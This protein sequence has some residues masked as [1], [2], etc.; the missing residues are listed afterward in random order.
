MQERQAM[1]AME[2]DLAVPMVATVETQENPVWVVSPDSEP[3]V[4]P[5][6]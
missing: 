1:A 3:P 6:E 5:T 2:V 4:E